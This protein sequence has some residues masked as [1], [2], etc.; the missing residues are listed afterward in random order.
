[1][2]FKGPND[3]GFT[4]VEM[5]I[6]VVISSI[7]VIVIGN[8]TIATNQYFIK[9]MKQAGLQRDL[10]FLMEMLTNNVREA[11][12]DSS[13]VYED[14]S[15][16]ISGQIASNG[17]CI[18]LKIPERTVVYFIGQRDFVLNTQG[19]TK[20][21]FVVD[22]IDTL[23]FTKTYLADSICCMNIH[24]AMSESG[25]SLSGRQTVYFRN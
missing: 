4:L 22:K 24:L 5:S 10:A 6:A 20:V 15:K 3:H 19:G 8:M 23:L 11:N 7:L 21:R 2:K 25:H 1:M 16:T 18:K 12:A 17:T 9:G 13:F 14:S